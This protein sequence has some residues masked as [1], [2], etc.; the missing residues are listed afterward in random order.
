MHGTVTEDIP[1]VSAFGPTYG[2]GNIC[3]FEDQRL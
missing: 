1:Q 3:E 2:M